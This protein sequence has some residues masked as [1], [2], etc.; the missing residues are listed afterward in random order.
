MALGLVTGQRREDVSGFRFA[1]VHDGFLWVDQGKTG[2]KLRIPLALRL[3]AIWLSVDEVIR[4]CRDRVESPYMVHS[5][6]THAKAKPGD[7]LHVSSLSSAFAKARDL[8]K[9][10]G[11]GAD[12]PSFHELRSL[13]ER[14]YSEQGVDTQT[15]LGHEDPRM[16]STYHDA[17]G[18][19]GWRSSYEGRKTE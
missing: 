10:T 14:L 16:T 2:V 18:A 8:A 11:S 3:N 7:A 1:D 6:K 19:G 12:P 9:V 17:R 4:R 5:S 15:L 13:A